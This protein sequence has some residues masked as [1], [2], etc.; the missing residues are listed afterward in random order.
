MEWFYN[1]NVETDELT[2]GIVI[3]P[4]DISEFTNVQG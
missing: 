2:Y 3:F 1:G 4:Q